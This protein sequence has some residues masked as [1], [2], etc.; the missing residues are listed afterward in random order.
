MNR[1]DFRIRDATPK[2]AEV[3]CQL[4]RELADYERLADKASPDP[5]SLARH[6]NPA[7]FPRCHAL[8]ATTPTGGSIGFALY[9]ANYS[10]FLTSWGVQLEDLFV[11]PEYRGRGVGEALLSAVASRAIAG[12]GHRLDLVVLDWNTPA[13]DF[14]LNRGAISLDDWT[15]MRFS[16]EALRA[17]A[18]R[19][20]TG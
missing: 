6:L 9:F 7:A 2:D 19:H 20:P 1:L 8:L 10:T 17:L 4:I 16:G 11:R 18:D 13:I 14:Y 12:G 3:L 5:S 15:T